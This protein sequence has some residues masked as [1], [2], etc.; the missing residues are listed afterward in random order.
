M[1]LEEKMTIDERRKYLRLIQKRY[2]KA[3]KKEKQSLLNEAEEVTG[4]HRKS[5]VRMLNGDLKR[6]ARQRSRG[7][8]YGIEV[9]RAL[10]VI[11]ESTDYICAERLQPNLV[12]L[13]QHLAQHEEL[14]TSPELLSQLAKIS[15]STVR[16][17]L[18]VLAQDQPRLPRK[19]PREANQAARQVPIRKIAWNEQTPGHF[20]ADL[21][22][23]SGP[24]PE[25]HYVHSLQ[26]I[27]VCTGWS[28]RVATL[29]RSYR[30]MQD[31]F[32]RLLARLP[33]SI[34]EVHFDNGSEFLNN[35]LLRF[36]HGQGA[37][38]EQEIK[39]SRGRPH[40]K[41][42]QRFVEQ[43]NNTLIRAYLG[44]DRFD[45]VA[46]THWMNLLY[47]KMWLY[48]N[49]FQPVIRLVEKRMITEHNGHSRVVRR[50]DVP[51][52]PFDRLIQAGILSADDQLKCESLRKRTNPRQLR[53][54]IYQMLEHIFTLPPAIEGKT[55]D[56]FE[57]LRT[58]DGE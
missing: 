50:Y 45:T 52:T 28:E 35:H 11:S 12:W 24:I 18:G 27:D 22:H 47:D 19:G 42:D 3:T 46:H 30:V 8:T 53:S 56:I 17:L 33:F 44:Y 4:L 57:T 43:K 39:L 41:N 14:D 1:N 10:G 16:R 2:R 31:G 34:R 26:L 51:R 38:Q 32:E 20:E 29:G 5:L 7:R 13:A 25:G 40:H 23:H 21:V 15:V 49:F 55:E 58:K 54:E 36:W 9:R 37:S 6:K 48:Y